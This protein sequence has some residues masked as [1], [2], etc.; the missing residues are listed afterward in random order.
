MS[1][2]WIVALINATNFLDNM[3]GLTAGFSAIAAPIHN[4]QGTVIA[5]ISLGGP[6]ARLRG[7]ALQRALELTIAAG[8]DI[9]RRLGG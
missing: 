5:A 7:A 2:I 8:K 6:D 1:D 3:D 4:H 9:S